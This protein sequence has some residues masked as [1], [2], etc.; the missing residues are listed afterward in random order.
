MQYLYKYIITVCNLFKIRAPPDSPSPHAMLPKERNRGRYLLQ[1]FIATYVASLLHHCQNQ[2]SIFSKIIPKN[3][4]NCQIS[5]VFSEER[6]MSLLYLTLLVNPNPSIALYSSASLKSI[7]DL[8]FLFFYIWLCFSQVIAVV[9]P[10]EL[11]GH[12]RKEIERALESIKILLIRIDFLM[13]DKII[14]EHFVAI[15]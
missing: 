15:S 2:A 4:L 14:V 1:C 11:E 3:Y 12:N 5:S 7:L 8:W 13:G 9:R 6:I 10:A